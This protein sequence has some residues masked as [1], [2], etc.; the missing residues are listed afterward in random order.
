MIAELLDL[1]KKCPRFVELTEDVSECQYNASALRR[2]EKREKNRERKLR[3][4][5]TAEMFR[6]LAEYPE[7]IEEPAFRHW[8]HNVGNDDLHRM[9]MAAG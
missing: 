8:A 9:A 5:L 4:Q 7:L 3:R 6:L 1:P 2:L